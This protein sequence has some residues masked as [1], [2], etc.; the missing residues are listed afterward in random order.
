MDIEK[1][2]HGNVVDIK[3]GEPVIPE[4]KP[5]PESQGE[6]MERFKQNITYIE[7]A[8]MYKG[9]GAIRRTV[10]GEQQAFISAFRA[11]AAL[12][13]EYSGKY[14]DKE[15]R[16]FI[17]QWGIYAHGSTEQI[18]PVYEELFEKTDIPAEFTTFA[19]EVEGKV[20]D[21]IKFQLSKIKLK[22]GL[23]PLKEKLSVLLQT[24]P[25]SKY[26]I[27]FMTQINE[28]EYEMLV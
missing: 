21:A 2:G 27:A 5:H 1:I 11:L 7:Q 18:L 15:K 8:G 14:L 26:L 4:I 28:R 10:E 6:L 13:K 25:N 19:R 20:Y 23:V 3:T 16:K 22:K 9:E 17:D 24:H 12:A